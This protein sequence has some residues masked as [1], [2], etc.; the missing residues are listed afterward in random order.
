LTSAAKPPEV[1]FHL[2]LNSET[3]SSVY[4]DPPLAVTAET[5]LRDVLLLMKAQKSGSVLVCEGGRMLGIFTERDALRLM[6][7]RASLDAPVQSAMSPN[8]STL[9]ADSTLGEA[10]Q[11]MSA[12]GYR[13][14]PI[15]DGN[16]AP[17]GVAN[18]RGIVHYLVQHFPEAIYNLPPT[19]KPIVAEREGA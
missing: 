17:Q 16:S 11:R 6:A 1:D 15:L 7:Q 9:A 12:G 10:I 4:P 8:V 3:V 14:L 13:R 19:P 18:V 5:P 2:S